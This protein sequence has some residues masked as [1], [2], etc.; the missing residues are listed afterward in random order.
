[1]DIIN[2]GGTSFGDLITEKVV[3]VKITR[4]VKPSQFGGDREDFATVLLPSDLPAAEMQS[5]A[6]LFTSA[7]AMKQE[8]HDTRNELKAILDKLDDV[9]DNDHLYGESMGVVKTIL[10]NRFRNLS[11]MYR[12]AINL[13]ND[14]MSAYKRRPSPT[15]KSEDTTK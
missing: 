6:A 10:L 5:R 7:E 4:K 15:P 1:M 12:A 13:K 14:G 9:K 11:Q 3:K 2:I 8:I